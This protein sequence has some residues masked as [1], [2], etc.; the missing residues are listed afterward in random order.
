[1]RRRQFLQTSSTLTAGAA[2]FGAH[3]AAHSH[4][5]EQHP[6][7]RH[8]APGAAG[9]RTFELTTRVEL[10]APGPAKAWIPLPSLESDYQHS[11]GNE[12][13]GNAA[14]TRV[15]SDG[16]YGAAMLVAEFGSSDSNPLVEVV[17]VFRTLDRR[18]DWQRPRPSAGLGAAETA[19]WTQPTSFKPTDGIVRATATKIIR[20]EKTDIGKA[21]ALYHWVVANGHREPSTPGCGVGDIRAMLESGNLSGKCADLNALF[22]GLARSVG[23]P[24]RD[25]YGIR[26][27][28]S[29]FGYRELGAAADGT[30]TKAQHCRAE[31]YLQQHG[32]VAMDPADVLK[33]MRMETKEW[34]RDPSHPVVRP[35]D[36]ALFGGWEGNWVG[37]NQANDV[38]LPGS[39][40]RPLAFV[41]YPQARNSK[42]LFDCLK[43]ETFVYTIRARELGSVA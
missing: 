22:V 31:V 16:A 38:T 36:A 34:I 27:A 10:N 35:V 42:G 21:R 2:M 32:W 37:Y 13:R 14:A 40:E 28:P 12:W 7:E 41:M 43:P 23:L 9:W 39:S 8:F 11:I 25:V 20:G 18:V 1:M 17:S 19:F 26:V 33:V 6:Q 15:V 5:G 3:G 24:A 4:H 29:A 30:V